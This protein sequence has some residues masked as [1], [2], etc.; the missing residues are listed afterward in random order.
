MGE[1]GTEDGLRVVADDELDPETVDAT[2]A[3]DGAE[4]H[5][6]GDGDLE[7]LRDAFVEAFNARDLDGIL[8]LV[9]AD[10]ECPDIR[11]GDG[12]G[13]LSEELEA[14]W[15]RSPGAILT[16]AFLDDQPVAV[17]WLPDQDGC[18][19]RAAVVCFDAADGLLCLVE[20]PDD[21]DALDRVETEEPTGEELD[22]WSDW[23]EWDRGEETLPGERA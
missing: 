17:G 20:M 18:W 5:S 10:I 13:A 11:D 12:V 22:E 7:T 15:E 6:N 19:C 3:E 21:A 16:R 8:T 14:I 4:R 2:A 9:R 1:L 23:A